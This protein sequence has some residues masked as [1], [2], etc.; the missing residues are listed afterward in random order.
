M[1]SR[2][3]APVTP[4][5]LRARHHL[6]LHVANQSRHPDRGSGRQIASAILGALFVA[7]IYWA[8]SIAYVRHSIRFHD[9]METGR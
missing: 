7:A 8:L 2:S 3:F 9:A 6:A 4:S 5:Q 1:K